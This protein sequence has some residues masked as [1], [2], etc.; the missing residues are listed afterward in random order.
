MTLYEWH[1]MYEEAIKLFTAQSDAADEKQRSRFS[2]AE[3]LLLQ[4]R[5]ASCFG[6]PERAAT[7]LSKI[8]KASLER[9]IARHKIGDIAGRNSDLDEVF[10]PDRFF[11]S[12][13]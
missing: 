2:E 10:T 9:A 8:S 6:T 5:E 7:L 1:W 13:K 3:L 4:A 12:D 11:N